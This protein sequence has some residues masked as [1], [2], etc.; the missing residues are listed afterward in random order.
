[1]RRIFR[2]CVFL[3]ALI[4]DVGLGRYFWQ[5]HQ[6][7]TLKQLLPQVETNAVP[8]PCAVTIR[9][10]IDQIDPEFQISQAEFTAD[11]SRA[12]QIWNK[13]QGR[14]LLVYDPQGPLSINLIFDGRQKL[15]SQISQLQTSLDQAKQKLSPQE[16]KYHADLQT[17][18]Q[19]VTDLQAQISAV[20]ARGGATQEVADQ[21]NAQRAA[22]Q[23]QAEQLNAEAK[24]LNQL[25]K[26]FNAQV[27]QL[28]QQVG[29]F[30][31][32]LN[33]KPEEG[34]YEGD[35]NRI[36]IYFNNGQSELIHT[37]AHEM[38]HA[39][40]VDHVLDPQAIMYA[41]TNQFTKASPADL[42]NLKNFCQD[43][44]VHPIN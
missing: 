13:A 27:S 44:V 18:Q 15:S 28:N 34:I 25:S 14:N 42:T 4:L 21:L 17:Y 9:Y 22:L 2:M 38:G 24:V 37:L 41:S 31:S 12:A 8:F 33:Q 40:G 39:I 32:Q 5:S 1:M 30:N 16:A 3:F 11:A 6:L 19:K 23:T 36:E 35:Q 7:L 10:R 26:N 29:A 43:D 20:N